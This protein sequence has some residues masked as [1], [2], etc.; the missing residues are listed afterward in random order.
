MKNR[1]KPRVEKLIA[2]TINAR[3]C[4]PHGTR[5]FNSIWRVLNSIKVAGL[6]QYLSVM[7]FDNTSRRFVKWGESSAECE[8]VLV[9]AQMDRWAG[10]Q[11]GADHVSGGQRSE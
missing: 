4:R 2:P 7:S 11:V 10:G 3:K 5:N 8:I 1:E 6:K 9:V